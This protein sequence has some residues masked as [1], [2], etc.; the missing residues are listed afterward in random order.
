MVL[1]CET[2]GLTCSEEIARAGSSGAGPFSLHP[3]LLVVDLGGRL[4]LDDTRLAECCFLFLLLDIWLEIVCF[5]P[6]LKVEI[7]LFRRRRDKP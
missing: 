4:W 2:P 5:F 6:L 3:I 7:L 1:V